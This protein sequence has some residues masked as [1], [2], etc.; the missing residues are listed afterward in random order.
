MLL[1]NI[2]GTRPVKLNAGNTYLDSGCCSDPA[3]HDG[4]NRWMEFFVNFYELKQLQCPE[5]AAG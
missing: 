3:K 1:E 2:S 4:K 5:S